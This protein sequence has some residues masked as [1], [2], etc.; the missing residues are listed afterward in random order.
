MTVL[1]SVVVGV[2]VLG[3]LAVVAFALFEMSPFSAHANRYRDPVTGKRLFDSP[4]LD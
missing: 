1:I 4:R 2:F 3:V